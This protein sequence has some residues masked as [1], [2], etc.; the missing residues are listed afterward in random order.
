[1][2]PHLCYLI[3]VDETVIG[4][5]VVTDATMALDPQ[6]HRTSLT[7]RTFKTK[8]KQQYFIINSSV[9]RL[10]PGSSRKRAVKFSKWSQ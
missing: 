2:L 7:I 6:P 3:C 4:A 1:M 5:L 10:V 8:L 9:T